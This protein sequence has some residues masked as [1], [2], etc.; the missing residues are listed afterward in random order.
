M[1]HSAAIQISNKIS[2]LQRR[3]WNV[4]LANAFD[5]M[6]DKDEFK[7]SINDLARILKYDSNDIQY[8]KDLLY[9]LVNTTVE[10]NILNK[11]K[12]Q[13]WGVFALLAEANIIDGYCHYS[14]GAI[15]RKRL[16]NPSMYARISLSLQNQFK[17][18]YALALFELFTDY[19]QVKN[20]YGET[21]WVSLDAFRD[22][23]GI[24]DN[25]YKEFKILNK[26]VIKESIQEIN[27]VSDL[28]IDEKNCILT[29]KVNRKVV[30]LKFL[31]QKNSNNVIDVEN[32]ISNEKKESID[33][34]GYNKNLLDILTGEFNILEPLARKIISTED[35]Y[36]IHQTLN[37]IRKKVKLSDNILSAS[38]LALKAFFPRNKQ[39]AES[40]DEIEKRLK[41]IS[42]HAFK[43]VRTQHSDE[44]LLNAFNDLDFEIE[45]RRKTGE[46]IDNLAG[47]FK[48][49]LPEPGQPYQFS[50]GY[51]NHLDA[52]SDRKKAQFEREQETLRQAELLRLKQEQELA[53][54][55]MIAA[56]I[57]ELKSNPAEWNS[58]H[59]KAL[60]KAQA[61]I[62]APDQAKEF[63]LLVK[64]KI[65]QLSKSELATLDNEA[66]TYTQTALGALNID[67]N[68][69]A[70]NTA[71]ENQ[72][73]VIIKM[74]YADEFKNSLNDTPSYLNYQKKISK[75]V[76]AEIRSFVISKYGF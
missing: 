50:N 1:K 17:S 8:L 52:E 19:F 47:W 49:R 48:A 45:K 72:K 27:A 30:A 43:K 63:N 41:E 37:E 64:A 40:V 26:K 28:Y 15:L 44:V 9:K 25:E 7:I 29:K 60:E 58:I 34:Q 46:K 76:D 67:I 75:K 53:L 20:N 12:Q 32:V 62:P 70:F 65:K 13:E 33:T 23:I 35:E 24:R 22:L 38:D 55:R 61:A 36:K 16:Y 57:E 71:K 10:W 4:L 6:A 11:D 56:K 42:Y 69:P 73:T 2:L 66:I 68:H 21:P 39:V 31:I 74:R 5:D 54:E 18:R 59:Q 3:A 51:Q 14:Y